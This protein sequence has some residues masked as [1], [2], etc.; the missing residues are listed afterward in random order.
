MEATKNEEEPRGQIDREAAIALIRSAYEQGVNYFDT[1]YVYGGG[2][3]EK[4][5]GEALSIYPR[6]SCCISAP[7]A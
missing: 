1:A 3:S 2:E 5:L 6:D 7:P 4:I